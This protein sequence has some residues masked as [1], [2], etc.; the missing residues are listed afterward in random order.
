MSYISLGNLDLFLINT[1]SLFSLLPTQP[2][3][4]SRQELQ[5]ASIVQSSRARHKVVITSRPFYCSSQSDQC[6]VETTV[7]Q[8]SYLHV[9]QDLLRADLVV[10]GNS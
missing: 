9:L 10:S 8:S 5:L 6:M 7:V 2:H 3:F 1:H 4:E